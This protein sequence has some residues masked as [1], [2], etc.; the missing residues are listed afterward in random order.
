MT[1]TFLREIDHNNIDSTNLKIDNK[2]LH[3][4]YFTPIQ[5]GKFMSSMFKYNN[6]KNITILDPG[7]G[8]GN[9]TLAFISKICEW[10]KKPDN[11]KVFLYEVDNNLIPTLKENMSYAK[12]FC[13]SKGIILDYTI[14]NEDF[15][16]SGVEQIQSN[17]IEIVDYIITNPP[18]KKM[19]TNSN[20]KKKLLSVNI[21]VPNYYAAFIALACKLLKKSGQLV[22]IVPRSFCNGKYFEKFRINL[23]KNYKLEHIHLF[24]NREG[25]FNENILQETIIISLTN[26]KPNP[27]NQ[28]NISYSKDAS[29][30]DY[31]LENKLLENIVFPNDDEKL[32]RIV[33]NTIHETTETINSLPNSLDDLGI[34]VSTGPIVDFREDGTISEKPTLFSLPM[35]YSENISK[36]I[37]TWP[38]TGKKPGFIIMNEKKKKNLR[39]PGIYVLVKRM[40]SKEESRRISAGIFNSLE[41]SPNDYVGFDNKINYYHINKHGFPTLELAAGLTTFLNSTLVDQ[42]FRTFSGSTQVN[43]SDLKK[44][45]YPSLQQ[46][47]HLGRITLDNRLDQYDVNKIITEF[48]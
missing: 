35:I 15:I 12:Q 45:K 4:Q 24:E 32:I 33:N 46:L 10:S 28:V 20:Y 40:T 9:L 23:V 47:E 8:T 38:I 21:D 14:K 39:P 3:G 31:S 26:Q 6:K 18:Y 2:V 1:I 17:N 11:I 7:S 48:L 29:F 22:F 42:Y 5:I 36:G 13:F 27:S 37:V 43:V 34:Q 25:L 41:V 30:E 19:A 16:I 44:I